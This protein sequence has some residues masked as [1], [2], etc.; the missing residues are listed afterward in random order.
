MLKTES[1]GWFLKN[2]LLPS[3]FH[4]PHSDVIDTKIS[5]PKQEVFRKTQWYFGRKR[6][7]VIIMF[8]GG[9]R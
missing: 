3:T 7:K 4:F 9:K 5:M 8:N 6:V 1:G 2:L